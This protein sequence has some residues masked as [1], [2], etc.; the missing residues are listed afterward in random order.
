MISIFYIYEKRLVNI[1]F[2][3]FVFYD[4]MNKHILACISMSCSL[5][6]DKSQSQH[7]SLNICTL[8]TYEYSICNRLSHYKYKYSCN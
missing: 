7:T 3:V 2:F 4:S 6:I 5:H 8:M 1:Q